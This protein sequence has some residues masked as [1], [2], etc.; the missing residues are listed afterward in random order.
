MYFYV[1]LVHFG[2]LRICMY[3]LV[4]LGSNGAILGTFL[5]F[6]IFLYTYEY[7]WIVIGSFGYFCVQLGTFFWYFLVIL[8][9]FG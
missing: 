9:T 6:G 7:F 4:L 8:G 3:F 1:P 2:I 5:D